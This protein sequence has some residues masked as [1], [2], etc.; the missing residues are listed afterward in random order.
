MEPTVAVVGV[1]LGVLIIGL[2][3]I[4]YYR[5]TK[6]QE[7][8]DHYKKQFVAFFQGKADRDKIVGELLRLFE[9]GQVQISDIYVDARLKRSNPYNLSASPFVKSLP[10]PHP[11]QSIWEILAQSHA[12]KILVGGPPGSG[13]TT[14]L[15]HITLEIDKRL[16]I[17]QTIPILLYLRDHNKRINA[18]PQVTL[19]QILSDYILEIKSIPTEWIKDQLNQG[20]CVLMFD[21]L[22]EIYHPSERLGVVNWINR[23]IE[24][25]QDCIFIITSRPS[26]YNER[27]PITKLDDTFLLLELSQESKERFVSNVMDVYFYK[28]GVSWPSTP[29]TKEYEDRVNKHK[30][31]MLETIHAVDLVMPE[32]TA[33]PLLL[34]LMVAMHLREELVPDNIK[35]LLERIFHVLIS[36]RSISKKREM[37]LDEAQTL[38]VLAELGLAMMAEGVESIHIDE[39]NIILARSLEWIGWRDTVRAFL[40]Y[41]KSSTG[42]IIDAVGNKYSF[43]HEYFQH[44]MA[45]LRLSG[46]HTID[47]ENTLKPDATY[48]R[49]LVKS[50][51][52]WRNTLKLYSQISDASPIVRACKEI[53]D[54]EKQPDRELYSFAIECARISFSINPQL[55]AMIS[56]A[57][58]RALDFDPEYEPYLDG[59]LN[60]RIKRMT[61]IPE[62]GV[63]VS[64]GPVQNM[65]YQYYLNKRRERLGTSTLHPYHWNDYK[66]AS[67]HA[68]TPISGVNERQALDY[69]DWLTH[70]RNDGWQYRLP[71]RAEM[72]MIWQQ[73]KNMYALRGRVFWCMED[74]QNGHCILYNP[75]TSLEFKRLEFPVAAS[76]IAA[77]KLTLGRHLHLPYGN[78]K[79]IGEVMNKRL[80]I[81]NDPDRRTVEGITMQV[82]SKTAQSSD[83]RSV[84][85]A[86]FPGFP[87]TNPAH[88]REQYED[89]IQSELGRLQGWSVI[90]E[91]KITDKRLTRG[92]QVFAQL[93]DSIITNI[94][95]MLR[96]ASKNRHLESVQFKN[97]RETFYDF[98][99]ETTIETLFLQDPRFLNELTEQVTILNKNLNTALK[100]NGSSL[101]VKLSI[102]MYALKVA[103]YIIERNRSA[104][105]PLEITMQTVYEYLRLSLLIS[106]KMH[107]SRRFRA[108]FASVNLPVNLYEKMIYLYLVLVELDQ[109]IVGS[110]PTIDTFFVVRHPL[111]M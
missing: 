59:W 80:G 85:S 8:E 111:E 99:G 57:L 56:E 21:G 108:A 106:S 11:E 22:D 18:D 86:T 3:T 36:D 93:L 81:A 76:A 9:T 26:G 48:W 104:N 98:V 16:E 14:L 47:W 64:D 35:E 51:I 40:D 43:A 38:A 39:A 54:N 60:L 110:I 87:Y 101:L 2:L 31:E 55:D 105:E 5:N 58:D 4:F 89:V 62:I 63:F 32:V 74:T 70:K 27:N 24:L 79:T 68:D 61:K 25:Y 13:K 75:H 30:V 50:G 45:A 83:T 66:F 44:Y 73:E 49:G 91:Q 77:D 69:C 107:E 10:S 94:R 90:F 53:L 20:H 95:D 100:Q 29:G 7:V 88:I 102:S 41:V 28:R 65:E 82:K 84:G 78:A 103:M 34:F 71:T 15:K 1:G 33:N 17:Q 96:E 97:L 52:W 67:A 37:P 72:D 19:I 23:Q 92:Q 109:R 12:P 46:R 6:K 42:I